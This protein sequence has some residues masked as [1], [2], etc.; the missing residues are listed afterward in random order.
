[1]DDNAK[2]LQLTQSRRQQH[3]N[4]RHLQTDQRSVRMIPYVMEFTAER[5]KAQ[6]LGG[7]AETIAHRGFYLR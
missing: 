5:L 4:I 1:M 3:K 2:T 7:Q 6:M